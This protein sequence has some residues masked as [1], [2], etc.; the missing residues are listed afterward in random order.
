MATELP[1]MAGNI[2]RVPYGGQELLNNPR[3]NKGTAFTPEERFAF[4][5]EGLL[6]AQVSTIKQQVER[7]YRN[8]MGKT[9][10]LERYVGLV[11]LQDRNQTLFY[12]L[13][14][15]YVEEMLPI[16]YTPTVGL[17]CQRFSHIYRRMR[18]LWITPQHRGRIDRVLSHA[19]SQDV[20]LIVV[21]D[22][23]RIL[24][25]GDQGAGGISI[26][27]GKVVLYT[28]GAGIHPSQT[29]PISLDVGTDNPL[30]LQDDLYLGWR[31]RRIRGK[32]YDD[33]V[34]EFVTAVQ[35]RFPKALL[36]WEDFSKERAFA[37]L[38]RYRHRLLS[39]NDDIQGTSA[40]GAAA[41]VSGARATGT[42]LTEQ[43]VVIVGGGAAGI[44]IA[45]Q[46]RNLLQ[47]AGLAG[48]ALR[49]AIVV[50]DSGGFLHTGRE[51]TEPAK[52]D[53]AWPVE[54]AT[55]QGLPMDRPNDL[56]AIVS[57]Y[58][59]TALIGVTGQPKMFTQ[60]IVTNMA[61]HVRRPVILP[62][63]NPNSKAEA[64][65]ADLIAWT[66]GRALVATGSPYDPVSWQGRTI[67]IGQ[68]NNVL[69]FPGVGLGSLITESRE[70]TDGMFTA[71]AEELARIV[72]DEDLA[73]GSLFPRLR[74]LRRICG[75]IAQAVARQA[76]SEGVGK[77][78]TDE[79]VLA[80]MWNPE[81]PRMELATAP[82]GS[83]G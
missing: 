36:Q 65:P 25:L 27:I 58:K 71:A 60:A 49:R 37:L 34:E 28:V 9:D 51:L 31:Q 46:F 56:E 80:A 83:R 17:A 14:V 2:V 33:F 26:S 39:L 40:V 54:M 70:V 1:G 42:P 82:P 61:R 78:V 75:R 45:R 74:D 22:N 57:A 12:R 38:D 10:P 8:I 3:Y 29:L 59:P 52:V 35:K 67:R 24:G 6:P 41:L 11:A 66:E 72:T 32:E 55:A 77:P 44:G 7:S 76:A 68:A 13:M 62:L 63:S 47:K 23:E 18:G 50:L 19:P 64:D 15:E 81:Y 79:Q 73:A 5:L 43:R 53:F 16:V 30:L 48:D 4:G 20:R 69:V 21:T